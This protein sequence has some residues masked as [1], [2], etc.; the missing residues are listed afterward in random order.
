[1]L[2]R[3]L[4]MADSVAT[5]LQAEQAM[6][7]CMAQTMKKEWMMT[8]PILFMVDWVRTNSMAA[9]VAINFMQVIMKKVE[10]IPQPTSYTEATGV[11]TFMVTSAM[12][13]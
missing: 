7:Y 3:T 13:P 6:T 12:I 4:S 5:V 1:M 2:P 9:T 8:V 11:T 10:G